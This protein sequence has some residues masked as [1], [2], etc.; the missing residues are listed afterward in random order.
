[1]SEVDASLDKPV[2]DLYDPIVA[3]Q[4]RVLTLDRDYR[5]LGQR[6]DL[7]VDTLGAATTPGEALAAVTEALAAMR[8]SLRQ[9]EEHLAV[10]KRHASRL[11]ID[12]PLR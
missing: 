4:R 9:A 1:M 6:D 8:G 2:D 5:E 11:F 7:A 10:A 12:R 3:L